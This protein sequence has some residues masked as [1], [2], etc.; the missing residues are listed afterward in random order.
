[1]AVAVAAGVAA[2]LDAGGCGGG[3]ATTQ[4]TSAADAA[5]KDPMNYKLQFNADPPGGTDSGFDAGGM[6][7]DLNDVLNP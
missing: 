6:K 4:P 7:K 3:P 5:L 2:G 1:M